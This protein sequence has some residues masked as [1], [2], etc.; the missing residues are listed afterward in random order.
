MAERCPACH[1]PRERTSFRCACGHTFQFIAGTDPT[2]G[3]TRPSSRI[4]AVLGVLAAGA[5]LAA[6]LCVPDDP[7]HGGVGVLLVLSGLFAVGASM[8]NIG[9]FFAARRARLV[10][11][12]LGRSGAR[13]VYVVLGGGLV[14]A[15][16]RLLLAASPG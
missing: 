4:G 2:G 11:S 16:A 8:A 9:W 14:G 13:V 15:G 12:V 10:T 6:Y 7:D 1:R 5:A 3:F